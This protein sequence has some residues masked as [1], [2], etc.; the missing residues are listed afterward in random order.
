[1]VAAL[2]MAAVAGA[3]S[4][5]EL[6]PGDTAVVVREGSSLMRDGQSIAALDRD[7]RLHVLRV[8]GERVEGVVESG[9]RL[10]G[11]VM[12]SDLEPLPAPTEE[13]STDVE[14]LTALGV[15]IDRDR[16]D[17]VVAVEIDGAEV[18]NDDLIHLKGL[19]HLE[20]VD[21]DG[22]A[23]DDLGLIHLRR[24][25]SV[26]RVYAGNTPITDAG[27]SS[28]A[29][30][31][32]L[33]VLDLTTTRITGSGTASLVAAKN[34]LVLNLSHNQLADDTLTHV[35][36]VRWLETLGLA[37]TGLGGRALAPLMRLKRLRVLNLNG[38]PV[39]DDGL[40]PLFS[41]TSLRLV[42]AREAG[43]TAAGAKDFNKWCRRATI[44]YQPYQ[45]YRPAS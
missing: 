42:H 17:H 29:Q 31:E 1:V 33:E 7:D 13:R 2:L 27:I 21:L 22:S 26:M 44:Y 41:L 12:V 10:H 37:G 3:E 39:G 20:V 14:A 40:L 28:L 4:S 6:Q 24:L 32:H 16:H 45:P 23:V 36:G 30:I 43:V 34:L 19:P 11:S 8:D 5:T 35:S 25:P 38:C 15:K 18:E 9:D